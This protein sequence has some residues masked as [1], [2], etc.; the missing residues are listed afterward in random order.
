MTSYALDAVGCSR[1]ENL[2]RELVA[3]SEV[4][5]RG[6]ATGAKLDKMREDLNVSNEG[7]CVSV[8]VSPLSPRRNAAGKP[9]K[10]L[11][12]ARTEA[13]A[14]GPIWYSAWRLSTP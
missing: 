8:C 13:S 14:E 10:Q 9:R 1:C 5:E 11:L 3:L 12:R 2:E 7:A 4:A 6:E